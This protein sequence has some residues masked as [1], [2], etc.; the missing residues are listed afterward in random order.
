MDFKHIFAAAVTALGFSLPAQA[1][2]PKIPGLETPS[3]GEVIEAGTKALKGNETTEKNA[4]PEKDFEKGMEEIEQRLKHITAENLHI[5]PSKESDVIRFVQYSLNKL[6]GTQLPVDGK[7]SDAFRQELNGFVVAK[8]DELDKNDGLIEAPKKRFKD[9][10]VVDGD[11][12]MTGEHLRAITD[13]MRD[14]KH[15]KQTDV[16]SLLGLE[17]AIK[18]INDTELNT[19]AAKIGLYKEST[20]AA[21]AARTPVA[22]GGVSSITPTAG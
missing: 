22:K 21:P 9:L 5:D 17:K 2:F 6:N 13:S 16:E 11:H 18:V 15:L 7:M 20:S 4:I 10:P 19:W 14:S 12:P 3:L 1:G 8:R